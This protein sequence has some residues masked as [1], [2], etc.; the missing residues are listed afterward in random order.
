MYSNLPALEK[1]SRNLE[2][3]FLT[4]VDVNRNI[5]KIKTIRID[6]KK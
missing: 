6:E 3:F 5:I 2:T 1:W 4:S